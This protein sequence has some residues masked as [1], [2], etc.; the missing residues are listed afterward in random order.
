MKFY[1]RAEESAKQILSAFQTGTLPNALSTVF[2]KRKDNV[3]CRAWSWSN[4]LIVALFGHDDARGFRQWQEVGRYVNKGEKGCPILVPLKRK[5]REPDAETGKTGERFAI[6]GFKH[7][8]V[9]GLGQ[10]DG[11]PL[12][13]DRK[14]QQFIETLPL[15]DVAKSWG[16]SVQT[17][18]GR[19]GAALGRYRRGQSIALGVENVATWA[20]ELLHAADDRLGN[21]RELGQHW[22]SETVAELGGSI[23]LH[24]IGQPQ[25]ADSGGCWEYVSAYA[26]R[27]N[28]QPITACQRVLKRTCDAVALI[29]KTAEELQTVQTEGRAA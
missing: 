28:I 8:I 14:A 25:D 3:P 22:R 11:K 15:I 2:V 7:A 6:Y 18:N 17:Y 19:S 10:T 27:A 4:Q 13:V 24:C 20:H 29:L 21:L 12:E 16:L 23:L 5:I 9:F 1:G 26:K